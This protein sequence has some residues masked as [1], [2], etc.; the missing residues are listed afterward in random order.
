MLTP[1]TPKSRAYTRVLNLMGWS[2]LIFLGLFTEFSSIDQLFFAEIFTGD[3]GTALYGL[4]S[5]ACYMAPFILGGVMFYVFNKKNKTQPIRYSIKLP[6]VTPL[7]ILGGLA[8]ITAGA[9]VNSWICTLIGYEIPPE[10]IAPTGYDDPS[11][12][13]MYM[14]VALSPAFAEEFLF[15]GVI[16]GNLRP[17][18]KAQAILISSALFALMHQNI[19]QLLYTFVGG[20]AMALMYELTGTIWCSVFFHLLNNELAI[21]TE[22]LYYGKFGEAIEPLLLLWDVI[23]LVLGTVSILILILYYRKKRE[24]SE[25]E[26]ELGVFGAGDD[27][28]PE[29][30]DEPVQGKT[31][32]RGLLTPGMIVFAAAAV[33]SMLITY[34]TIMFVDL[35]SLL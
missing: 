4:L 8:V 21:L 29:L 15:R 11:A 24:D 3:A 13:I 20:V 30:Y 34:L 16:Y 25:R 33:A 2:L 14:T 9:Y 22:I 5:S 18:G 19:G 23:V 1:A 17:F 6:A 32:L 10:L 35:E 28:L 26:R 31:V 7:L 12:V 27:A